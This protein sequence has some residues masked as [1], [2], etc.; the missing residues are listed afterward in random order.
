M[1]N[2]L[3]RFALILVFTLLLLE[4]ALQVLSFGVHFTKSRRNADPQTDQS[5]DRV[6]I[7]CGDSFTFGTGASDPRYSYPRQLEKMLKLESEDWRVVNVGW[8]GR[9]S[10]EVVTR[11]DGFLEEHDP[12]ILVLMIGSNDSWSLPSPTQLTFDAEPGFRWEIRTLRLLRTFRKGGAFK[13]DRSGHLTDR[14]EAAP[15]TKKGVEAGREADPKKV[16]DVPVWDL[17]RHGDIARAE[18]HVNDVRET[19]PLYSITG[20]IALR[21]LEGDIE[22]IEVLLAELDKEIAKDLTL[23]E[24][25]SAIVGLSQAGLNE[26]LVDRFRGTEKKFPDEFQML[27]LLGNAYANLGD[28][29]SAVAIS[30]H[31]AERVPED[32]EW[33]GWFLRTRGHL[34]DMVDRHEEGLEAM[35]RAHV[36]DGNSAE[37]FRSFNNCRE[38]LAQASFPEILARMTMTSEQRAELQGLWERWD[39]DKLAP[40]P[41]A[42]YGRVLLGHM[43]IIVGYA[44]SRGVKVVVS[45]YPFK[46]LP[47]QRPMREVAA[48]HGVPFVDN[49]ADFNQR[50]SSGEKKITDL[51]VTDGHCTDYGYQILATNILK[52]IRSQGW[53]K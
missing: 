11:I 52:A 44:E 22:A 9:N 30:D 2:R 49:D 8:P 40:A 14:S 18:K 50:I 12:E 13:G 10:A 28:F 36:L 43:E 53:L 17:I 23:W 15:E 42:D 31:F 45:G 39:V 38:N 1:G 7:C 47:L 35:I 33:I 25:E 32:N 48:E 24:T 34:L 46:E 26:E 3:S 27:F 16:E 19:R 29:E 21:Q 37:T 4:G 51:Y 6:V 20:K 41:A 5:T